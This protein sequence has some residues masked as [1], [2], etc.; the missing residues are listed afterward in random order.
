MWDDD[1]S[2]EFAK[3]YQKAESTALGKGEAIL[4]HLLPNEELIEGQ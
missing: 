2:P 4:A 1:G 3:A